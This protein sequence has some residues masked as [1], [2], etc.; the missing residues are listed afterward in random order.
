MLQR[1]GPTL[2]LLTHLE[3]S[4]TG[5]RYDCDTLQNLSSVNGPLL[6][7]YDLN[8]G[9]ELADAPGLWRYAPLLPVRD[10]SFVRFLGEGWTPLLPV[11]LLGLSKVMIKE[12]SLNPTGSFKAR[13]MAVAV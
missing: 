1:T 11:R 5:E 13:G 4:R 3:C 2:S 8:N 10:W 7:R 6:A 12:E 9:V